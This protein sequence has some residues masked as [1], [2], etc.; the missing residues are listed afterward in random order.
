MSCRTRQKRGSE[1][2]GTPGTFIYFLQAAVFHGLRCSSAIDT[3]LVRG[4]LI[5]EVL[6]FTMSRLWVVVARMTLI[7]GGLRPRGTSGIEIHDSA[8]SDSKQKQLSNFFF[9]NFKASGLVAPNTSSKF[10]D[11]VPRALTMIARLGRSAYCPTLCSLLAAPC[12]FGHSAPQPM[13]G[14]CPAFGMPTL[15]KYSFLFVHLQPSFS[16]ARTWCTCR[17][18][19]RYRRPS[20]GSLILN[21]TSFPCNSVCPKDRPES[22][23]P[24][25]L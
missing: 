18:A 12:L 24:W 5:N 14:T 20:M 21:S 25:T 17:H 16:S 23:L 8:A 7:A 15:F 9:P 19:R 2:G 1:G 13:V 3:E 4:L 10:L 11:P 6:L 22:H